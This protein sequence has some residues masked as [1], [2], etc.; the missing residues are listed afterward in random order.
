MLSEGV[1][2]RNAR[3]IC[4]SK[5]I[6][7]SLIGFPAVHDRWSGLSQSCMDLDYKRTNRMHLLLL[8]WSLPLSSLAFMTITF[9]G[10][11]TLRCLIMPRTKA[12]THSHSTTVNMLS[13][14][15][16]KIP[17]RLKCDMNLQCF[18]F[19]YLQAWTSLLTRMRKETRRLSRWKSVRTHRSVPSGPALANIGLSQPTVAS[20]AP[21]RPSE[22]EFALLVSLV[23]F[24]WWTSSVM[25]PRF[26][27]DR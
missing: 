16:S 20:S 7:W 23:T 24:L 3:F 5:C 19:I 17:Y 21:P 15:R 27:C 12:S 11:L 4:A 25:T 1:L 8:S 6:Q 2:G 9:H 18:A 13:A 22:Y 14:T 10:R 26:M